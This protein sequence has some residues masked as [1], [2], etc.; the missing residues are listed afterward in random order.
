MEVEHVVS[1][2]KAVVD[3]LLSDKKDIMVKDIGGEQKE[4]FLVI[5]IQFAR[6]LEQL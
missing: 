5:K 1:Y 6:K 2:A 3:V 4:R